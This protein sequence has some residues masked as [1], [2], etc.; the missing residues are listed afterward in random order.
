MPPHR[1]RPCRQRALP[2]RSTACKELPGAGGVLAEGICSWGSGVKPQNLHP[3]K[4]VGCCVLDCRAPR[5]QWLATMLRLNFPKLD[6]WGW[7]EWR[8]Q[9]PGHAQDGLAVDCARSSCARMARAVGIHTQTAHSSFPAA[10]GVQP[11]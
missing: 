4:E 9:W 8:P 7:W 11:R 1:A 2:A 10:N 5:P 3:Y 6:P